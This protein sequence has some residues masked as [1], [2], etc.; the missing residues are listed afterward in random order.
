MDVGAEVSV[1][2]GEV[3]VSADQEV[4]RVQGRGRVLLRFT[5]DGGLF[6]S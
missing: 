1:E 4:H 6:A 3:P 5:L 2:D